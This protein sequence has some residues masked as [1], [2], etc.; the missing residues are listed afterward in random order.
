MAEMQVIGTDAGYSEEGFAE[1]LHGL[2][3]GW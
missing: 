2:F 1:Y 3:S